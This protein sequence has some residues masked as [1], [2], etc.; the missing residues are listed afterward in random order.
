VHLHTA[1]VSLVN[2][3]MP[4]VVLA[5]LAILASGCILSA[6]SDSEEVGFINAA[7]RFRDAA[8]APAGCPG[9]FPFAQVTAAPID[10]GLPIPQFYSCEALSGSFGYPLGAYDVTIEITSNSGSDLDDSVYA[11]S[12]VKRVDIVVTD[13]VVAEDFIT[14]GGRVVLGWMLTDAGTSAALE[15]V[16]A[17]AFEISLELT[18]GEAV[19]TTKLPCTAGGGVSNPVAAGSYTAEISV[20][21]AAGTPLGMPQTQTIEVGPQNDYQ[22]VGVVVLPVD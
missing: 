12:L 20:L 13:V 4:R 5:V 14:D 19:T 1:A 10:G 17:G 8:G 16:P 6:D 7:W 3:H 9:A 11:T 15:C 22:D 21:D 18:A 2:N